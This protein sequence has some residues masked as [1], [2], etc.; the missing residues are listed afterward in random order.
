MN[1]INKLSAVLLFFVFT[2]TGMAEFAPGKGPAELPEHLKSEDLP[3]FIPG[4]ILIKYKENAPVFKV[5]EKRQASMLSEELGISVN[6]ARRPFEKIFRKDFEDKVG[7]KRVFELEVPEAADIHMLAYKMSLDPNVEYAEPVYPRNV[8]GYVP[9]DPQYSKQYAPQITSCEQAWEIT[10][11]DSVIIAIVDSGVFLDHPDLAANIWK[12]EDD[13]IDGID[14]DGNGKI[15]DYQGWDFIGPGTSNYPGDN[16]PQPTSPAVSHGTHVAGCAAAVGDNGVGVC[17]PAFKAEILPIKIARDNN[18]QGLYR[19][20]EAIVYA[21]SMGADIINCSWG[22]S[23]YQQ[24]EQ[25]AIYQA[26]QYNTTIIVAAGN[27]GKYMKYFGQY[28]AMLEGVI[29]IGA[30]DNKDNVAN[31]SNYG[32]YNCVYSPGRSI[33]STM[34]N[35]A[36]KDNDGTSMAS[37]VAAGIAALVKSVHPDWTWKQIYHQLRSTSDDVFSNGSTIDKINFFGRINAYKAVAYNN[38]DVSEVEV[39]GISIQNYSIDGV[40][41]KT[42]ALNSYGTHSVS[43]D[44]KNY[45]G[46]AQNLSITILSNENFIDVEAE[47]LLYETMAGGAVETVEFDLTVRDDNPW[48]DGKAELL[49]KYQADGYLDYEVVELPVEMTSASVHN[50]ITYIPPQYYI[51][52]HGAHS[53]SANS[54]WIAGGS[55][56]GYGYYFVMT[57]P[58]SGNFNFL[59]QGLQLTCAYGL[60]TSQ[61]FMGSSEGLI[62]KSTNGGKNWSSYD[63]SMHVEFINDIHFYDNNYGIALGDPVNNKFAVLYTANGGAS[64]TKVNDMPN[65]YSQE[66]G[67]V[68]STDY[69]GNNVY[70]GTNFGRLLMSTDRGQSWDFSTVENGKLIS[71][72]AFTDQEK[73]L[74]IYDGTKVARTRDGGNSWVTGVFDF[75]SLQQNIADLVAPEGTDAIIAYTNLGRIYITHNLGATWEAILSYQTQPMMTATHFISGETATAWNVGNTIGKTI[76]SFAPEKPEI[77]LLGNTPVEFDTTATGQSDMQIVEFENTGN[78]V[79]TFSEAEIIVPDGYDEDQF[80]ILADFTGELLPG[81]KAAFRLKFNPTTAGPKSATLVVETTIETFEVELTGQGIE[82]VARD[83]EIAGGIDKIVFDDTKIGETDQKSFAVINNTDAEIDI[84]SME[85]KMDEPFEFF[86]KGTS[87]QSVPGDGAANIYLEFAPETEGDKT[88]SIDIRTESENFTLTLTG[89][90]ISA[91]GIEDVSG[92]LTFGKIS[93]NPA[94]GS[95]YLDFSAKIPVYV[96]MALYSA[97][98]RKIKDVFSELCSQGANKV[99]IST[100]ELPAGA[101]ILQ[102]KHSDTNETRKLIVK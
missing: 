62:M 67:F 48:Y 27:D 12:N 7:L 86:I 75:A 53:P 6:S 94:E 91:S 17:G 87:D 79:V 16:N 58:N 52:F 2:W 14:N 4:K 43:L 92:N 73:G 1:K 10:Q 102:I 57:G 72:I 44:I 69:L 74:V 45:L 5:S 65:A 100:E 39:P 24:T 80:S 66:A 76:Y 20:Y 35:G 40:D 46:K 25:E 98:G 32:K 70:F 101:Y 42:A 84:S 88:A 59:G 11:G 28:P 36:Y 99:A 37:P 26:L 23:G 78:T 47:P 77:T 18:Q 81:K 8:T 19:G 56:F 34:P 61:G 29:S 71:H 68:G 13:P 30:S 97:D 49:I 85:I 90:A 60:S 83:L 15:D 22:G 64:W 3:E 41:K 50:D 9:N 82:A 31:F 96:E 93:P 55:A 89:K 38:P 54:V 63:A 95:A 51:T 21:A 33:Y